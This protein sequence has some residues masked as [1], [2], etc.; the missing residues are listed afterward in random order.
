[1]WSS[2]TN[3]PY[4]PGIPKIRCFSL[5]TVK[6]SYGE[7]RQRRAD[8]YTAKERIQELARG[9]VDGYGGKWKEERAPERAYESDFVSLLFFYAK[10]VLSFIYVIIYPFL[11]TFP[12]FNCSRPRHFTLTHA[13]ISSFC[14]LIFLSTGTSHNLWGV[15]SVLLVCPSLLFP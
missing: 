12:Y 11:S 9:A 1:M 7:R 4:S 15:E 8:L 2:K 10:A 5:L 14:T 3:W 6:C 13:T